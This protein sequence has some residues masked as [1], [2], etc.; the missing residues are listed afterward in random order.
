MG[1]K[2]TFKKILLLPFK[3]IIYPIAFILI[4]IYEFLK[5]FFSMIEKAVDAFLKLIYKIIELINHF[6]LFLKRIFLIVFNFI[7]RI[8][9]KIWHVLKII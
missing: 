1:K 8:F 7:K 5:W 6:F 4:S 9:K 3:I 2:W